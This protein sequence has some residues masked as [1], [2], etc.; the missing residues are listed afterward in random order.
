MGIG[1]S[2][3]LFNTEKRRQATMSQEG[4]EPTILGF[5]RAKTTCALEPMTTET[6]LS[7]TSK[8]ANA[9]RM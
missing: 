6:D 7:I 3:D 5:E 2:Q 8:A 4:F 9:R 1:P